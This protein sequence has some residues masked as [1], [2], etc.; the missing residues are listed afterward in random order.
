MTRRVRYMYAGLR[1]RHLERSVEFYRRMGFREVKRGGFSHGGLWVWLR[2]PGSLQRL[3]LNWYPKTS[4]FYEPFRKGTEFDHLGFFAD[5]PRAWY[6]RARAAGATFA[7]EFT[8]GPYRLIFVRD[9]DGIWLGAFGLA[10]PRKRRS[11]KRSG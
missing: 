9:P 4:S 10:H 6:R 7:A 11:R 2:F 3:E 1:V 5:D 8:D